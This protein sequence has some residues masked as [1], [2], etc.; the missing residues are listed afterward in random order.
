MF[1]EH[2]ICR[3]CGSNDLP[4]ALDLGETALA[5]DFL[6]PDQV[7]NYDRIAPLRLKICKK[8]SLAQ[9][10]E[11]VDPEILYS[12]Y[13]Y[14]TSNSAMMALH[15]EKLCADLLAAGNFKK[16][17]R[18]L[19][20]GSNTGRFLKEFQAKGCE[21]LGV[22]PAENISAMAQWEGI[23]TQTEF[24]N[25]A[26]AQKISE[27]W[28]KADLIIG[29]HVFAHIDD[30]KSMVRAFDASLSEEG[31]VAV[32]VPYLADFFRGVQF[33]TIYH[34][35]LSYVSVKA[36]EALL[37][38]TPLQLERVLRYTI[39]GGSI[40]FVIKKR[41]TSIHSSVQKALKDEKTLQLDSMDTWEKFAV[42]VN[43]I[44]KELPQLVRSLRKEGKR[45]IGYGASA[46]GSTLLNTCGIG[47][48]D[49]DYIIDNT[50]FKQG[51]L[52]PGSWIPIH[53]PDWLL[54]DQPDFALILAWNFADEII[55]RENEFQK[56]G[57]RFIVPVPEP[58][59][60][61]WD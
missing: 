13:A 25:E 16:S 54:K 45:V 49:L 59:I 51:K 57:G 48:N 50:P 20:F 4:V 10:G 14:I 29:R 24:F 17:P 19:E 43:L 34:E 37:E 21:V 33:D 42:K 60:V 55:R 27:S 46:K 40:V 8:C 3:A 23:P 12:R 31:L 9:L 56:R 38:N 6:L 36:M 44:R 5:N 32:E 18:V 22:E 7:E 1:R 52:A 47:K 11:I 26:S 15:L 41:P 53:P 28:G 2:N 35:H 61:E 39:H 58:R 30:W